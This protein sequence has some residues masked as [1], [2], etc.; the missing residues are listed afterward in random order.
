MFYEKNAD[1]TISFEIIKEAISDYKISLIN[2]LNKLSNS[3]KD[4]NGNYNITWNLNFS[5]FNI[6]YE[7][8]VK[9]KVIY[10]EMY[11]KILKSSIILQTLNDNNDWHLKI[12]YYNYD[13]NELLSSQTIR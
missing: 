9:S 13:T 3:L 5:E 6:Y 10:Y 4:I 8:S 12:N 7:E 1:N 11:L 2:N